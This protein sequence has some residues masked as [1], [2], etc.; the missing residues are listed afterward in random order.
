MAFLI[1]YIIYW[2]Y[3]TF[4]KRDMIGNFNGT[5]SNMNQVNIVLS[6]MPLS[7]SD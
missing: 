7:K 2:F 3:I 6:L 5:I 1:N 4:F